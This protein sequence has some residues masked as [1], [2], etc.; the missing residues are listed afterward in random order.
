MSANDEQ[1]KITPENR[2]PETNTDMPAGKEL[3]SDGSDA[4]AFFETAEQFRAAAD[5]EDIRRL[6]DRLGRIVFGE[7]E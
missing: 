5:P 4:D 3:T 6:G 1:R 7:K 2:H